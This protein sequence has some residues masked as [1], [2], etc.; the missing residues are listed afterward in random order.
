MLLNNCQTTV[1]LMKQLDQTNLSS[2]QTVAF[3]PMISLRAWFWPPANCLSPFFYTHQTFKHH[4][5]TLPSLSLSLPFS[6]SLSIK[7]LQ[8]KTHQVRSISDCLIH[9]QTS[10][11]VS[12]SNKSS[13]G[14][15]FWDWSKKKDFFSWISFFC[16]L[17]LPYL[18]PLEDKITSHWFNTLF[19]LS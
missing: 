3:L 15:F 2:D 13:D 4:R 9:L 6:L 16:Q 19:K 7:K 11:T 12:A 18:S 1:S 10:R 8:R 17:M 14:N 5:S